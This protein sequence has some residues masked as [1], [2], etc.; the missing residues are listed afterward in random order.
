MPYH[1]ILLSGI[2]CSLLLQKIVLGEGPKKMR[3]R[4]KQIWKMRKR[5]VIQLEG[6]E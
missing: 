6:K 5:E 3:V 1:K 4:E 2:S